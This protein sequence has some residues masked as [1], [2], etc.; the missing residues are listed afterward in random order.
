[1]LVYQSY[2]WIG[3]L[4]KLYDDPSFAVAWKEDAATLRRPT[5]VDPK[6][7]TVPNKLDLKKATTPSCTYVP[8]VPE[9]WVVL[10]RQNTKSGVEKPFIIARPYGKGMIVITGDLYRKR[11]PFIDN[12]VE[13]NKII[14]RQAE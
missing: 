13:Y 1:M 9:K 3:D 8:K 6:L 2:S 12:I 10:G 11:N 14:P 4:P 7:D 5:W